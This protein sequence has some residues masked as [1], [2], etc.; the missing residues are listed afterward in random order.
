MNKKRIMQIIAMVLLLSMV[1]STVA[2]AMPPGQE[3]MPPG[4][5][6]KLMKYEEAFNL[7][8]KE[9]IMLGDNFGD[10]RLND[11]VKRGDITVMIVR[12]F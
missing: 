8:K 10:Y 12:A 4:Q 6:K 5:A 9:G 11:F 2:F 3:K 1:F 7:M